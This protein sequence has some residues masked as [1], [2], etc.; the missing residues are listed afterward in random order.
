MHLKDQRGIGLLLEII[1][2]AIIITSVGVIGYKV[3]SARTQYNS[4]AQPSPSATIPR[5]TE[6]NPTV[7][8]LEI[9]DWGVK[10]PQ[11]VFGKFTLQLDPAAPAATFGGP[12]DMQVQALKVG[13]FNQS[14]NKCTLPFDA[15]S[16]YRHKDQNPT[17][18]Y[19]GTHPLNPVAQVKIG[20]W[21]YSTTGLVADGSCFEA[22]TVNSDYKTFVAKFLED[23]KTIKPLK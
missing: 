12:A 21:W 23:F 3:Y 10:I 13:G 1:V 11:T 2:V 9:K 19:Q 20:E 14:E 4:S 6:S 16:I 22:V 7:K 15:G 17:I 8:Q 5:T 18:N